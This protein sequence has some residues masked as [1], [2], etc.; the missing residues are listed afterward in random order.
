VVSNFN[1]VDGLGPI[2]ADN[3]GCTGNENLLRQCPGDF[4][5]NDNHNCDHSEDVGV[6]CSN[7]GSSTSGSSGSGAAGAAI[8]ATVGSIFVLNSRKIHHHYCR[9]RVLLQNWKK[10]QSSKSYK[11][12]IGSFCG[13]REKR[14]RQITRFCS[15]CPCCYARLFHPHSRTC[16]IRWSVVCSEPCPSL[17]TVGAEWGS[18]NRQHGKHY[19]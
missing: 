11:S 4:G 12:H 15:T 2:N 10:G 7:S 6:R 18:A 14:N 19:Y 17:W 5:V 1:T 13:R 16:Q 3:L 8:G 9:L